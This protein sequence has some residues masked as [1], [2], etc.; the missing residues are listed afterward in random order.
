MQIFIIFSAIFIDLIEIDTYVG[1]V[2]MTYPTALD[3]FLQCLRVR[4]WGETGAVFHP[5]TADKE[6]ILGTAQ[7][8]HDT[9]LCGRVSQVVEDNVCKPLRDYVALV[10]LVVLFFCAVEV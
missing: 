8:H 6:P 9:D 5:F 4:L 10:G 7:H 2:T 3:E 1:I